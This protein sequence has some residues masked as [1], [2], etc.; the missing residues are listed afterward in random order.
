MIK[1]ITKI[2]NSHGIIFD[3]ALLDL[4]H[5][6]S[7]DEVNVAIHEGGTITLTPARQSVEPA[8]AASMARKLI[9]K[10]AELFKRLS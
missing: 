5:L 4:A 9:K 2:G 1:T 6:K 8:A 7:G 10:N 3:A